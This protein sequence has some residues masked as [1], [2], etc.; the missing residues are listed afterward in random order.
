MGLI[1]HYS[2][3]LPSNGETA[4]TLVVESAHSAQLDEKTSNR[5][6]RKKLLVANDINGTGH[7]LEIP[8]PLVNSTLPAQWPPLQAVQ[9]Y[10][11]RLACD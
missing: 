2:P 1:L 8:S 9:S 4:A 5:R 3:F 10:Q 7:F 11:F 6:K